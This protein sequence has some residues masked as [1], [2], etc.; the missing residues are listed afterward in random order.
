V[1]IT[2]ENIEIPTEKITGYL[3]VSKEK[4]DKSAFL[5]NLGYTLN[6]WSELINDIRQGN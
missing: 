4:N 5:A 3:L 1:R 6:N 2:R